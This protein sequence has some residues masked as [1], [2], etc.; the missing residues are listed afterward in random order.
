MNAALEY[1]HTKPNVDKNNI[2][3]IGYCFGGGMVLE[4]ARSGADVKA[5]TSF[6]GALST[7]LKSYNPKDVKAKISVQ[8]GADDPYI[9]T[10]ELAGFKSEMAKNNIDYD[11]VSYPNAV[12]AF[13]Q[14]ESGTDNSKG[15]AYNL[16][17]DRQS[18]ANTLL[19]L[20]RELSSPYETKTEKQN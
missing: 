14:I 2:A 8:H 16:N 20:E 6:H 3:A 12:H 7:A 15:A 1:L 11:F 19:F 9:S 10:E 13:T 4:L 18:W 5:V 17:A